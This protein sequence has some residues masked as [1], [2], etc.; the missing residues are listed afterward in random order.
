[1]EK[2]FEVTHISHTPGFFDLRGRRLIVP[3]NEVHPKPKRRKP[4]PR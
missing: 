4:K 1:M 2:S 3:L